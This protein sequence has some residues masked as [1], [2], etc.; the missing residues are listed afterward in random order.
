M[1]ALFPLNP[2]EE[3]KVSIQTN[4]VSIENYQKVHCDQ[5]QVI[6]SPAVVFTRTDGRST[7]CVCFFFL[8][9]GT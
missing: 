6:S 4:T 1:M 7:W 2:V 3:K 8:R 5:R 9:I